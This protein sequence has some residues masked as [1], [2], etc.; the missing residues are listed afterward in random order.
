MATDYPVKL[1]GCSVYPD[2]ASWSEDER[3]LLVAN[4]IIYIIVSLTKL[5]NY[6]IKSLTVTLR[7]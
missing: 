3:I 1:G 5:I 6:Y 2:A 7:H 4:D